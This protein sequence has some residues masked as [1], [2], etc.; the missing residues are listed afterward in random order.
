M[1]SKLGNELVLVDDQGSRKRC[2]DS[3]DAPSGVTP[4]MSM[5]SNICGVNTAFAGSGSALVPRRG[6]TEAAGPFALLALPRR[7]CFLA[8]HVE[9]S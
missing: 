8:A 7:A 6:T 9:H 2:Q 3:T 1:L 5:I 4:R